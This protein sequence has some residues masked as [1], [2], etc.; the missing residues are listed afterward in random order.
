MSGG[1]TPLW[2]KGRIRVRNHTSDEWIPVRI[3]EAQKHPQHWFFQ[4]FGEECTWGCGSVRQRNTRQRTLLQAGDIRRRDGTQSRLFYFSRD[5]MQS[6]QSYFSRDGMQSRQLYFS[7]DGMQSRLLYFSRKGMQS[8][9]LFPSSDGMQSRQ[10]YFSRDGMQSRQLYFSRGGMQSC[11]FLAEIVCS[12][13]SYSYPSRDSM[14]SRQLFPSIDGMQPRQL[15]PNKDDMPSCYCISLWK[16]VF[17]FHKAPS[18]T[19]VEIELR[20]RIREDLYSFSCW[21]LIRI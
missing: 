12:H 2:E 10:L 20:I 13:V 8:R 18:F 19:N 14:Q 16:I 21:I 11:Y 6:R 1:S 4:A 15:F 5:G 7:R 9:Q 17:Y 3:R